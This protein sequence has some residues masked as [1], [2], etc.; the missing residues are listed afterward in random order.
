MNDLRKLEAYKYINPEFLQRIQKLGTTPTNTKGT[1]PVV[2][3]TY[4]CETCNYKFDVFKSNSSLLQYCRECS[5]ACKPISI[6]T[7]SVKLDGRWVSAR[8]KEQNLT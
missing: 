2:S 4:I 3:V 1:N 6:N 7:A 8:L 5:N